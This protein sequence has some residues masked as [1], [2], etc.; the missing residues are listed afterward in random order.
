MLCKL[1]NS[2]DNESLDKI[3]NNLGFQRLNSDIFTEANPLSEFGGL[4]RENSLNVMVEKNSKSNGKFCY[5]SSLRSNEFGESNF[6]QP[7]SPLRRQK[8]GYKVSLNP[9]YLNSA[10]SE[11][12]HEDECKIDSLINSQ[13]IATSEKS[14]I[15]SVICPSNN[16]EKGLINLFKM[17]KQGMSENQCNIFGLDN[18]SNFCYMNVCLQA[19]LSLDELVGHY[20][21]K[22]ATKPY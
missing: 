5:K 11:K 22:P 6:F 15:S 3:S 14:E 20:M 21:Q 7:E 4:T 17:Y 12:A 18:P 8:T 19:L 2:Q 10:I 9:K 13:S 16:L 1:M